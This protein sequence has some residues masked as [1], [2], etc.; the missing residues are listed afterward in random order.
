[1]PRRKTRG[2]RTLA[3][4]P[5]MA[6]MAKWT[7]PQFVSP[8]VVSPEG[9]TTV[10][11]ME[12]IL[13]NRGATIGVTRARKPVKGSTKEQTVPQETAKP[14]KTGSGGTGGGKTSTPTYIPPMMDIREPRS[15]V[16]YHGNFTN[17]VIELPAT[18][19]PAPP[20][21]IA[22]KVK[23]NGNAKRLDKWKGMYP[24]TTLELNSPYQQV[25]GKAGS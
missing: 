25:G 12:K 7:R 2:R 5:K 20:I 13:A 18:M 3:R 10:T 23:Q 24:A 6:R 17:R 16:Q 22:F 21:N 15:H 8:A 19:M 4:A 9:A 14:S 11:Q 1:M